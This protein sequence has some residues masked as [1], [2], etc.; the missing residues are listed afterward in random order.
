MVVAPVEPIVFEGWNAGETFSLRGARGGAALKVPLAGGQRVE[1]CPLWRVS[2]QK[3]LRIFS[4]DAEGEKQRH[5][6]DAVENRRLLT[7]S[8]PGIGTGGAVDS[9]S[10]DD[11]ARFQLGSRKADDD[12]K[13]GDV[14]LPV[15]IVLFRVFSNGCEHLAVGRFA[16]PLA[17]AEFVAEDEI[18]RRALQRAID[19]LAGDLLPPCSSFTIAH[20]EVLVVDA[21]E[22]KVQRPSIDRSRP[23]QTGVTERS[24][25]DGNRHACDYVI[26]DVM[27][28]HLAD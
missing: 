16:A 11:I 23:H 7:K 9:Q 6:V 25:G 3:E 24:I 28:G 19:G 21:G 20:E 14:W 2:L 4:V 10:Y 17:E 18:E 1:Q 5:A 27:V 26:Q 12:G 13:L 15:G 22:I 8:F